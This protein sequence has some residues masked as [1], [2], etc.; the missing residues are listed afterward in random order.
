[1]GQIVQ[2]TYYYSQFRS[3]RKNHNGKNW[4]GPGAILLC[5]SVSTISGAANSLAH[6]PSPYL[7]MHA[8]DLVDWQVWDEAVLRQARLANKLIF[9]SVGY[10]SCHL[11]A[12]GQ[13]LSETT[14]RKTALQ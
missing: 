2:T 6:H 11:I 9:V 1:M 12:L 5:I 7:V 4:L 13:Q 3:R 8:D 10:F 14:E